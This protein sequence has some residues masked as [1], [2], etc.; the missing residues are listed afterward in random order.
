M[1]KPSIDSINH[2]FGF[3]G[4]A[5]YRVNHGVRGDGRAWTINGD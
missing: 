1:G 5:L 4:N 3:L 2:L